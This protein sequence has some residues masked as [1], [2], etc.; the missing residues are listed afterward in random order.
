MNAVAGKTIIIK[1]EVP[2]YGKTV[3]GPSLYSRN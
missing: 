3:S 2:L 1:L